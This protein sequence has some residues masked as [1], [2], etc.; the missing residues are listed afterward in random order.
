MN[1][2]KL[3]KDL[4]KDLADGDVLVVAGTGVSVQASG[5]QPCASWAGL[6]SDGIEHCLGTN[7]MTDDEAAALHKQLAGKSP[8]KMIKVAEAVSAT[9]GAPGG[10]FLRWLQDSVGSLPLN[11]RDIIDTIHSLGAPIATTNY[12]DLL[13]RGRGIDAV[14]WTSPLAAE[15]MHG[16]REAVL[17]L[18]GHY[19]HPDSVILGV[20]S[21]KKIL[22]SRVRRPSS[23]R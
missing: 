4:C 16:D 12:D 1:Q 11:D 6:I 22:A 17:H 8:A 19:L 23:R 14:P 15:F 9:L 13:T 7:L 20:N 10:E 21:Y 2:D 3:L 5:N 18:H